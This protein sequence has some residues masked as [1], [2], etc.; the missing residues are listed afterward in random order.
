MSI[1]EIMA[2]GIRFAV[3]ATPVYLM[4]DSTGVAVHTLEDTVAKALSGA[5][6]VDV[7]VYGATVYNAGAT[8]TTGDTNLVGDPEGLLFVRHTGVD[9]AGAATTDTLIIDISA[10]VIGNLHPGEAQIYARSSATFSL[11][12]SANDVVVEYANIIVTS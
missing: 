7:T 4:N 11:H 8:V 3:S 12:A 6:T 9:S 5:G 2:S 1:Q 10:A